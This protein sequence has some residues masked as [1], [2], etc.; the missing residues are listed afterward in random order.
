MLGDVQKIVIV[1]DLFYVNANLATARDCNGR[2]VRGMR[3]IEANRPI[4]QER[5]S[6]CAVFELKEPWSNVGIAA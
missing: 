3:N 1:P 5:L 6:I 2:E 4:R